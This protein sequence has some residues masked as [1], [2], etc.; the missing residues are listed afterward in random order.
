MQPVKITC[1]ETDGGWVGY[2]DAYPDY[3]TQG[4]TLD[5]LRAHLIDL[6]K[7]LEEYP[8]RPERGEIDVSDRPR[9]APIPDVQ[10]GHLQS[11]HHLRQG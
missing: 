1:W 9:I 10:R 6:W 11:L 2:L 8:R 4:N 3:W 7:D 5:D